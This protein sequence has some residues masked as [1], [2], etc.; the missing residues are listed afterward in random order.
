MDKETYNLLLM[1]QKHIV[2][3]EMVFLIKIPSWYAVNSVT[4]GI[5]LNVLVL[6]SIKQKVTI[7]TCV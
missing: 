6:K 4:N 1:I 3:V 7:I 2:S 5:I